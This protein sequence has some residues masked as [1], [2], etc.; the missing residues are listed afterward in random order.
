[1]SPRHSIGLTLVLARNKGQLNVSMCLVLSFVFS[2][3]NR[4]IIKP[5]P[6]QLITIEQMWTLYSFSSNFSKQ[7][8]R[9][10]STTFL[11]FLLFT[12]I[13][14]FLYLT[15]QIISYHR[16]S[17][18]HVPY[19]KVDIQKIDTTK[20]DRFQR[21]TSLS[22]C[23]PLSSFNFVWFRFVQVNISRTL[24]RKDQTMKIDRPV[25]RQ[26]PR[27]PLQLLLC[28]NIVLI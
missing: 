9:S 8:A 25:Q 28:H 5:I 4:F 23:F 26:R 22:F 27:P 14:S 20:V 16:W 17:H 24:I 13:Q 18:H 11:V 19:F 12:L 21:K 1:M 15:V 7:R 10:H 2:I 3:S 6:F